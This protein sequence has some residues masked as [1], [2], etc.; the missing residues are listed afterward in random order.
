[1]PSFEI[2]VAIDELT[3]EQRKRVLVGMS[4]NL[5]VIIYEKPDALMVPVAA[6]QTEGDKRFVNKR[7]GTGVEK[8][9]VKTGYTTLDS[10]E[11]LAGLKSGDEL[12]LA[13]Q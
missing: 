3:P 12:V 10:V 8:T 5:E 6:V 4:A 13:G 11:V 1:M 7:K 2:T 9:E